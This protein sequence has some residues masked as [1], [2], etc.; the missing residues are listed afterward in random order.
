VTQQQEPFS[1]ER[2]KSGID[3][4]DELI[5]GGFLRPSN[6]YVVGEPGSG[7]TTFGTQFLCEGAKKG[8]KGIYFSTLGEPAFFALSYMSRFNFYDEEAFNNMAYFKDLYDEISKSTEPAAGFE[9]ILRIVEREK[10]KR[11]VIDSLT[12][13]A[14]R[15]RDEIGY[16]ATLF[17]LLAK[18]KLN[19]CTTLMV[20][21]IKK[22]GADIESYLADSVITINSVLRGV[23]YIKYLRIAK[24]RGVNHSKKIYAF[25]ITQNGIEIN[26]YPAM[27][28][29]EIL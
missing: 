12:P 22:G 28:G 4:L 26:P 5:G 23:E 1:V 7:K 3:G 18:L 10:P 27:E 20:G 11:V 15:E 8:E 6:I 21:E 2:L 9:T 24:M 19:M 29:E 14:M 13:L 16:R 25:Q 17:E